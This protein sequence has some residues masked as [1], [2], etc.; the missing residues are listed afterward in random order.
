VKGI[1]RANKILIPALF[2]LLLVAVVRSVTLPGAER[3]L[4]FMFNP[5]LSSL[6]NYKTWLEAITQSAW[7][8]GAGWGLI[9]TYGTYMRQRDDIVLNSTTIGLGDNSASL[10][11]GLAVLPA[12]FG[13]LSLADAQAAMSA[14]NTGLMFIWV[15]QLFE[16][17][18]AGG[19]FLPLFFL[20]LFFAAMSSLIA[21]IE[22][23]VRILLDA[24]WARARAVKAVTG[25]VIVMGIPSA[26]SMEVFDNQDWVWGLALMIC[27]L[28][29][30][31]AVARYGCERFRRDFINLDDG[32][33]RIGR[34]WDFLITYLIP[35]EFALMFG[36]WVYQAVM[37]YDPE[38]WWNPTHVFSIGTC[39][40][41]WAIALTL[42]LA[43]NRRV[44]TASTR[45]P[46]G[47]EG[48]E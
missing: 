7:S 15:P 12:A 30:A 24:G 9:L 18:P 40:V 47:G 34:G 44:A 13:I 8:T 41:Q 28:F 16:R 17:I 4:E 42:L 14:G 43:F 3:G 5:D 21:M 33:V 45:P 2:A 6:T 20:A 32:G 11:A 39:L 10:L 27:G 19:F 36:W 1:E 23:A 48:A 37:V 25:A 35:V 46:A 22:L 29:I 31:L 38:G 26:V